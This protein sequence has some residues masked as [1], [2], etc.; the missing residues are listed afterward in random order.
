M[1]AIEFPVELQRQLS[2]SSD[3]L[4]KGQGLLAKLEDEAEAVSRA[5][6]GVKAVSKE[7]DLEKALGAMGGDR[8]VGLNHETRL[9]NMQGQ[10]QRRHEQ[11]M[12]SAVEGVCASS[13]STTHGVS[14]RLQEEVQELDLPADQEYTPTEERLLKQ[15]SRITMLAQ[16]L[17]S[18]KRQLY[19]HKLLSISD[20]FAAMDRNGDG[21]V[22][23]DELTAAFKRLGIALTEKEA[24]EITDGFD[25]NENGFMD[26]REFMKL[27]LAAFKG[28][29]VDI[30]NSVS[31][32]GPSA[33][34]E[35]AHALAQR[36]VGTT[37]NTSPSLQTYAARRSHKKETVMS[38]LS[39]LRDNGVYAVIQHNRSALYK[40]LFKPYAK[41]R[42]VGSPSR[43]QEHN[44]T[45]GPYHVPTAGTTRKRFSMDVNGFVASFRAF[46]VIPDLLTRE[47]L[48]FL[49]CLE[50]WIGTSR[51]TTMPQFIRALNTS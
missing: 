41:L 15:H 14:T 27:L 9:A 34:E 47:F 46:D 11:G 16:M 31:P 18:G 22:T 17:L 49:A 7:S 28:M 32:P 19:K 8:Q 35:R 20:A 48:C 36:L 39:P 2:K 26:Y 43:W 13:C 24:K 6:P 50:D 21:F 38:P 42:R 44:R 5:V 12:S 4:S 3:E 23:A 30:V 51:S 10:R 29:G 1:E 45:N 37:P 25:A 40:H 33:R